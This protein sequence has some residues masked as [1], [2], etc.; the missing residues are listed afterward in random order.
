MAVTA[1]PDTGHGASITFGTTS[2]TGRIKKVNGIEVSKDAVETTYL[3][4][5]TNKTFMAGD[6]QTW[7]NLKLEV[8]FMGKDGLPALGSTEETVTWT[9][10]LPGGSAATAPNIA[11]TGLI[12]RVKYPDHV[13]G[14][15]QMG[16]IE[17][18]WTGTTGPT[19][20]AAA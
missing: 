15:L 13:T 14:E 7:T 20:T 12:T 4:T 19:Y 3:G 1:V 8:L 2:W 5:S 16:E 9:F 17:V 18:T 11:G 10:P 6:L